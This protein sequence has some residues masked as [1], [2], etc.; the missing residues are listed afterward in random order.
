[1]KHRV[2]G[3]TYKRSLQWTVYACVLM[4]CLLVTLYLFTPALF[5]QFLPLLLILTTLLILAIVSVLVSLRSLVDSHHET[6]VQADTARNEQR[7]ALLTII[8][9][10]T[11]S[12][13]TVNSKGSIRVYNAALLSL[14]DTNQSLSGKRVD[15]VLPLVDQSGN[16]VSLFE[17]MKASS[18]FER[19]DLKL[20]FAEGDEIRLHLSVNGIKRAF[21]A[22][23]INDDEGYVCIA[24]DITKSKSLE[25]ERDEFI[26][27]ISHELRTPVTIAEGTISNVQ[28]FLD[29]G[30]D[31]AKLSESLKGAHEQVVLLANMINDLGTLSR[32]ERGVGDNVEDIDVKELAETL[33]K[34]YQSAAEKKGLTLNLD[35]GPRLGS[36]KTSRLYLEESLQNFITNA[37]KYTHEGSVT[38][39]V[40]RLKT[41]V[42]F[43]ISDTG[44]GMSKSDLK[45]IFE[46]FFRSEDYRTR[47]TSGTGLG[48]YVVSKL[49]HKLGATVDVTSRLNHGS[50]FR[51]VVSD[52]RPEPEA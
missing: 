39:T 47:E 46:K 43:S 36:L 41:G 19:D 32:A 14:L 2:V 42:E 10:T 18:H 3:M 21:S 24:R 51:F 5:E 27:V 4:L 28:Y 26:S 44:I 49:M 35:L 13:F 22:G 11:Q 6:V 23:R 40:K 33:Y 38:L 7:E 15:D 29:H 31:P 25:E 30:A 45:H 48:L 9:G 8:N 50:T 34:N 37:I 1:M 17:L 16:L 52:A 12:I 20:K